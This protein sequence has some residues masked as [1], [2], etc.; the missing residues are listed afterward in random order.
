VPEISRQYQR[1]ESFDEPGSALLTGPVVAYKAFADDGRIEPVRGI[2]FDEVSV[3]TP[4]AT[5]RMA[6]RSAARGLS[7]SILGP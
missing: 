7:R 5:R 4:R 1:T 6:D 2:T 3:R